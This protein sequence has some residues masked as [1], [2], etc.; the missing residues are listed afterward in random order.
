VDPD[1]T[2]N[3][4]REQVAVWLECGNCNL[5]ILAGHVSELDEWLSKGGFL[6]DPWHA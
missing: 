6:P 4:I 2:L 3:K 5:D 1:V